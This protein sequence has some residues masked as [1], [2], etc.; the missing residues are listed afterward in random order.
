M[1]IAVFVVRFMSESEF[2]CLRLRLVLRPPDLPA[3]HGGPLASQKW[4]P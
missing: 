3:V 2:D 1:R 4:Q